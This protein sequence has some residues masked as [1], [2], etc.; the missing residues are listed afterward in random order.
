[1]KVKFTDFSKEFK[2][3]K[4]DI[5]KTFIKVGNSG[6]YIFGNE[7]LKFES[8]IKKFLKIKYALGLVIGQRE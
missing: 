5:L 1:M 7:L 4:K 3:Y 8:N 2:T 6:E